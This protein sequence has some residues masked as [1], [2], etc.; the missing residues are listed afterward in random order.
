MRPETDTAR[1]STASISG[2]SASVTASSSST[3]AEPNST[4]LPESFYEDRDALADDAEADPP[5]FATATLCPDRAR[6]I[7]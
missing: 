4:T 3:V 5:P 2:G 1:C 6:P 7:G